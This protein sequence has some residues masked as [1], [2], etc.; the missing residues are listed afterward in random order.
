MEASKAKLE[1]CYQAKCSKL[2]AQ[3]TAAIMGIQSDE[4]AAPKKRHGPETYINEGGH[5]ALVALHEE[6]T[7]RLK[8]SLKPANEWL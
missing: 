4:M 7:R 3:H 5:A 6:A 2:L 1:A 8:S